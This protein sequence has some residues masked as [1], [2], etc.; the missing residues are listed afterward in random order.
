MIYHTHGGGMFSGDH[1][2]VLDPLL[3]EAQ[4]LGATL[5]SVAY[6]LAPE[7]PHPAPLDDVHAGLLWT[8]EHAAELGIDPDRIIAAGTSAGGGLTAALALTLRDTGGPRL[9]GTPDE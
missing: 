9:L 2:I 8:V 3:D 4:A 5:V 6:R 1:R 7:H